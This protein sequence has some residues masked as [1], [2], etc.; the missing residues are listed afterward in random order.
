MDN[1][2][3]EQKEVIAQKRAEAIEE[4]QTAYDKLDT[5]G[6]G[7]IDRDELIAHAKAAGAKLGAGGSDQD[8]D[9]FF[10]TFD[11]NQDGV[12]S[13][14]EWLDFFGKL[15]DDVIQKGLS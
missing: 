4:A 7:H 1:L 11:S 5:N 9:Q 2:T 3:E 6:D 10:Q 13:K 12:V 8:V 15:F 14:E